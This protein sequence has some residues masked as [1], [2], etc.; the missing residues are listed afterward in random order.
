[1]AESSLD[2][3]KLFG[4]AI[5]ATGNYR[6]ELNAMDEENHPDHGD[7]VYDNLKIIEKVLK[8]QGD[9]SPSDALRAAADALEKN[10]RGSTA[11]NY[12]EGLHQA[13]NQFEG[14][15]KLNQNDI[16]SLLNSMLGTGVQQQPAQ[17]TA[18]PI[19]SLLGL[20]TGQ[21]PQQ[22][23]AQPQRGAGPS[24]QDILGKA[25]PAAMAF[26]SAK[27]SGADTTSAAMQ[28]AMSALTGSN[29]LE[30]GSSRGTSNGLIAQT[31]MRALMSQ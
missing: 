2:L 6:G 1:M 5:K 12:A 25:L 20:V 31:I 4:A 18:D 23:A 11:P 26:M 7:H 24:S 28:A 21:Q 27:A 29:P 14:K 9:Q 15:N 30:S 13:A 8:S 3:A 10:G 17:A 16:A 19:S 22:A